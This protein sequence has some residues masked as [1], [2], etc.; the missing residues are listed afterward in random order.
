[1]IRNQIWCKLPGIWRKRI[2]IC[3]QRNTSWSSR[4]LNVHIYLHVQEW[5]C[6]GPCLTSATRRWRKPF[7]KWKHCFHLEAAMSLTKDLRMRQYDVVY[8]PHVAHI[9]GASSL[10]RNLLGWK[11]WKFGMGT[12][13]PIQYT[14]NTAVLSPNN[15]CP[16]PHYRTNNNLWP[17]KNQSLKNVLSEV[18]LYV[19]Q[20]QSVIKI[21]NSLSCKIMLSKIFRMKRTHVM[22]K[23]TA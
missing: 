2:L 4:T 10:E 3:N 15:P 12:S 23:N 16:K 19:L 11:C 18:L 13:S 9:Y 8:N 17:L 20:K 21:W 5:V 6:S 1:M 22:R 7:S 14:K